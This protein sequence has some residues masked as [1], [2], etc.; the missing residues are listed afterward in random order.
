M[1]PLTAC[2]GALT[3]WDKAEGILV[4]SH[5][6]KSGKGRTYRAPR[7]GVRIMVRVRVRVRVRVKVKVRAR[8]RINAKII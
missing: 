7:V 1:P 6:I 5:L 4:R 8:V 2:M 3:S